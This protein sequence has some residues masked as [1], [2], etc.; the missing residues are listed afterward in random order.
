M[1]EFWDH[2]YAQADYA[3]GTKPNIFFKAQIDK[4]TPGRILLPGEGEGRNAVYAA[5]RGWEVFA[6]DISEQ[7]RNKAL[8]LA[9]RVGVEIHYQTAAF[10]ELSLDENDFD[11][12][13]IIFIHL[14]PAQ[15]RQFH[16]SMV[17]MLKKGGKLILEGFSKE[18]FLRTTGG[19]KNVAMLMSY[20]ELKDDFS[21]LS[22]IKVWQREVMLNEGEY[23][24]GLASVIRA[25]GTK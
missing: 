6:Y 14:E 21:E 1:S 25:S 18:Q 8:R 9:D 3:Y 15:R 11:L 13:A 5:Q 12:L 7:A 10:D 4:L 20:E 16:Q 23:H 22:R 2:R 19:P 24:Q 17:K